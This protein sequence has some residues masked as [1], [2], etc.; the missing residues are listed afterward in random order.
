[1]A[2][3]RARRPGMVFTVGVLVGSGLSL[4]VRPPGLVALAIATACLWPWDDAV[5]RRLDALGLGGGTRRTVGSAI[6]VMAGGA[7]LALGG[8]LDGHLM[9]RGDFQTYYVGA[10]VGLRHGWA[11]IF[12]QGLL[13]PLWIAAFAHRAPFIPYLNT[14]PQAWLVAPLALLPF[15]AAF[16]A[17]VTLMSAATVLAVLLVS[18]PGWPA[19]AAYSLAGMS[20]WVL[21]YSLAGGQ[22]AVVGALALVLCWRLLRAGRPGWAGIALSLIIVRPNAT[23]LVPA[24]LLVAGQRR[25]FVT[26]LGASLVVGGVVLV[27]LGPAGVR[28]FL[29]LGAEIRRTHPGAVTMTVAY[30]LGDGPAGGAVS[31]ILAAAALLVAR[32]AG[33]HHPD[34]A[35]AAGLLASVFLTPYIHIQDFL[36]LVAGAAIVARSTFRGSFGVV[37]VALLVAAPPGYLFGPSW[38]VLLLGVE[39]AW[40]GWSAWALTRPPSTPAADR[41]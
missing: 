29:E 34:V 37:A 30:I 24:A 2:V 17:W 26:W 20:L 40:L 25:I 4:L 14:P 8:Q 21:A 12:D 6:L 35:I 33:P 19:R 7:N 23:F 39:V 31:I 32:R 10:Q 41:G 5:A 9:Y 15:P 3:L 28:Q 36:C 18:P 13:R 16:A 27:S 38:P 22:N 1:M 11:L